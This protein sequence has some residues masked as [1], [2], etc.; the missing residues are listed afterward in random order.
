VVHFYFGTSL[1]TLNR[2]PDHD[3][4]GSTPAARLRRT[5]SRLLWMRDLPLL[6]ALGK[7]IA[8]TF[9][10]DD[11]RQAGPLRANGRSSHLDGSYGDGLLRYD[12]RKQRLAALAE[13][14]ADLIYVTNPDLFDVLPQQA[15]FLPYVRPGIE[16]RPQQFRDRPPLRIAHAPSNPGVKGTA[17]VERAI[18]QLREAGRELQFDLIAGASHAETLARLARAHVFVDQLRVGWY[19]VAATEALSLGCITLTY[20]DEEDRRRIPAEMARTMPIESVTA[21]SLAE[22]LAAIDERDSRALAAR[23]AEGCEWVERWHGARST[24]ERVIEDYRKARRRGA[25]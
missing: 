10:G 19:G 3:V 6:K 7:T 25:G 18:G 16:L 23:S 5:L 8:M 15:Q 22:A 4:H 21:G 24:A 20:L 2:L 13:R 17:D 11:I 9:L 12:R 14:Y 1:F